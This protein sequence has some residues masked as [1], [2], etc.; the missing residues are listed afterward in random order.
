VLVGQL[1]VKQGTVPRCKPEPAKLPVPFPQLTGRGHPGRTGCTAAKK[2]FRSA[3]TQHAVP[4]QHAE[5]Q[6]EESPFRPDA[7]RGDT[8]HYP[9]DRLPAGAVRDV[10]V[11]NERA[12]RRRLVGAARQ[13]RDRTAQQV[14]AQRTDLVRPEQA[15][16]RPQV[17]VLD[18]VPH[19][20]R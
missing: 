2:F 6:H 7:A 18:P 11:S 13:A 15:S 19:R 5:R 10:L 16:R 8:A 17:I 3:G 20:R 4:E 1:E 14:V 9:L 12:G